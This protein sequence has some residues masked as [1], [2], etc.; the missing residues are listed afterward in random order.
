MCVKKL[1]IETDMVCIVTEII[2]GNI[3]QEGKE[4]CRDTVNSLSELEPLITLWQE[5][6]GTELDQ[7]VSLLESETLDPNSYI[8]L[9]DYQCLIKIVKLE[10][11]SYWEADYYDAEDGKRYDA[12]LRKTG[13]TG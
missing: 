4:M 8:N 6:N 5:I 10:P 3:Q 7:Y 9:S 12:I 2:C 11:I 1:H 13:R